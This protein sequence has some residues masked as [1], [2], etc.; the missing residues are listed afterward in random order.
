MRHDSVSHKLAPPAPH[1]E[2]EITRSEGDSHHTTNASPDHHRA[3][4]AAI[5]TLLPQTPRAGIP[6]SKGGSVPDV[7]TV[8]RMRLQ[9]FSMSGTSG[10]S[11]LPATTTM[12][13]SPVLA[14]VVSLQCCRKQKSLAYATEA[15]RRHDQSPRDDRLATGW[16]QVDHWV[17]RDQCAESCLSLLTGQA[18]LA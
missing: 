8:D 1:H 4:L 16:R 5:S 9:S 6:V 2:G 18:G 13:R 10:L 7:E 15:R 12:S 11:I 14:S 17:G 3:T